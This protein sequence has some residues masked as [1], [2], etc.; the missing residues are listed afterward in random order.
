ME[1][2]F[3]MIRMRGLRSCLPAL[4]AMAV[5]FLC[6]CPRAYPQY[7]TA[8]NEEAVLAERHLAE[9]GF[10]QALASY[11]KALTLYESQK[12]E[13]GVLF[14]LERM[15]W[16]QRESGNYGEALRLFRQAHPIGVRLN[17]DAAE[18]DA[19]LGDVYLFSGDS[20]RAREH[21][22]LAL[23]TL[24]DF[25]FPA[26]F[27]RPPTGQEMASMVR[28]TKAIMHARTNL[29]T[30]HYFARE[31]EKALEQL[32]MAGEQIQNVMT[33]AKHP[34]YGVFFVLDSDFLGGMGFHET[35]TGA[36]Y[37]ELGEAV[38][39]GQH[40]DAGRD[41]LQRGEKPYGLLL[42]EALR[43]RAGFLSPQAKLDPSRLKEYDQFLER[44][45]KAGAQDI[46]WR[47]AYEIGR[48]L[49][50]GKNLPEAKRY[51]ARSVQALEQTRSM[52]REDTVKKMFAASVQ[53]V[54][55]E[56]IRVLFGMGS[57]E[58]GF[59][60]LER[61]R[62]RAFLD[63]LAG[64]SVRA[65]KSVDP[66]LLQKE[67]EV[68][69]GL[70][71]LSRRLR[72]AKGTERAE[73]SEAYRTLLKERSLLLESIKGQSLEFA[74]TTTVTTL[75]ARK[76]AD[77]IGKGT[78]LISY[79]LDT[80][81]CLVWVLNEGRISAQAIDINAADLGEL[82]SGYRHAIATLDE[83]NVRGLGER[84][85]AI[86]IKPILGKVAGARRLYIVPS[87]SLQYLPFSSLPLSDGRFLVHDYTISVLP[88]ASS[89]F[90]LDKQIAGH[91]GTLFA[92]GNPA[93]QGP[94]PPLEFAEEEVSTIAKNFSTSTVRT[95]K[96]ARESLMKQMD[97]SGVGMIHIAAHGRF[98]AS[99]P[100]KSALLLAGDD[101]DDGDLETFEIFSLSL[102]P[103]LVVL[104]AC[105]S[106]VGKLEGGDEVQGLNRAFLYAGSGGVVSSLWSVSDRS[107]YQLMK[108]FYTL[109]A[110]GPAAEALRE[111]QIQ[112]MKDHP[113]PFHWAAFYLTGG[114][115]M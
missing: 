20:I 51:L 46:V 50:R 102:N 114:M 48:T 10:E 27:A 75:P 4:G 71:G 88:N 56:M 34:L 36:T 109:L 30:M 26:G 13:P 64:R 79:F 47:M 85:S 3:T 77:R 104:S 65:K 93:R 90:F 42:N 70:E 12:N 74:A 72:T 86:L 40:F 33:V 35:V 107:T 28:K 105:E 1:R 59:E 44:A 14:C 31:Y 94:E 101:K 106:G 81:R 7:Q 113:M 6:V 61:S 19:V 18:I 32:R 110:A 53:D 84:L 111:A 97:L 73:L 5:L 78:A 8:L 82:V 62:A 17:G 43:I 55:G 96:E 57:H 98:N 99:E 91:R 49:V 58:E 95:G 15:G 103:R 9:G 69:E 25:V 45:G 60:Y 92:L 16:I 87:M 115:D 11:G 54:Y 76:I 52:L 63:M 89:L 2:L 29:G 22:E 67:R 23:A 66:L 83:P 112:L 68:G 37:A 108:A 38:K 80:P 39:A 100:L 41:A 24:K 21:Y